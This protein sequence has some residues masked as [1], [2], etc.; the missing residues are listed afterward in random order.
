MKSYIFTALLA[1][2]IASTHASELPGF[3]FHYTVTGDSAVKPIQ[4][5]DDGKH[6]YLQFRDP[7]TIPALFINT[8][9]GVVRLAVHQQFP[10]IVADT[11]TPEILVKF[12]EQ[13]AIIKYT[14][15]RA[16]TDNG[17]MTGPSPPLAVAAAATIPTERSV[18]LAKPFADANERQGF[19]GEL[20]FKQIVT[21][22]VE[23]NRAVDATPYRHTQLTT[24]V[25]TPTFA[26]VFAPITVVKSAFHVVAAG[27]SVSSIARHC[28]VSVHQL[29]ILNNL[30]NVNLIFV[31][32]KL[33][34]SITTADGHSSAIKEISMPDPNK[35]NGVYKKVTV[36]PTTR[37]IESDYQSSAVNGR[38]AVVQKI[39]AGVA[40]M[41]GNRQFSALTGNSKHTSAIVDVDF[42]NRN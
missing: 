15:G 30:A 40:D 11:L 34:L 1:I 16:L 41:S 25:T 8:A 3:D 20:I 39:T 29:A 32:Q 33:R 21:T 31:G 5:F 14:G 42:L 23:Q 36:G 9:A 18:V 24:P 13:Q 19:T 35:A 28:K 22:S 7:D 27:E 17:R 12:G 2:S 6:L 10:Y 37:Q 4:A 38:R 26:P